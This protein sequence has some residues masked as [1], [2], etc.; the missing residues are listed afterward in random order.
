M[1]VIEKQNKRIN[2]IDGLRGISIILVLIDHYV[3][4]SGNNFLSSNISF[5][6]NSKNGVDLFFI[7]SGY[8]ITN[9]LVKEHQEKGRI[10]LISFFLKRVIRIFPSFYFLLF[11]YFILFKLNIINLSIPTWIS[12]ILFLRQFIGSGWETSHFWSLSV[13]NLFYLIFP[14]ILNSLKRINFYRILFSIIFLIMILPTFRYFLFFKTNM[15]TLNLFFRCDGLIFGS[16]IGF[17]TQFFN[18]KIKN[19]HIII[20]FIISIS[21]ILL[22]KYKLNFN[23]SVIF[24][25]LLSQYVLIL[26]V[27]CLS[28]FFWY[29]INLRVGLIF[30]IINNSI[31]TYI[32][33]MSYSIYLWQQIFFSKN[34]IFH[35]DNVFFRLVTIFII[36]FFSFNFIETPFSKLKNRIK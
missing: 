26:N 5:F 28:L 25:F 24:N 6:I 3:Y 15:S 20:V 30:N 19:I 27:F 18:K 10:S 2:S 8:L 33:V 23:N 29:V 4:F 9:I 17:I 11:I 31:L 13:E 22:I 7:I 36:S 12:S 1:L 14:L 34:D 35:F 32:G 21:L 16:L